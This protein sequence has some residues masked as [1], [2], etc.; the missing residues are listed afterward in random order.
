[1]NYEIIKIR[2][3]DEVYIKVECERS[4]AAELSEYFTFY[5][6]GY[7]F[8]PAFR[9]KLWDGKIRLFNTQNHTLYGGLID[10]VKKFAV[11]R[12]YEYEIADNL[13]L[14]TEFSVKEASD[15][16]ATLNIPF[17]V[18]DYQLNSFIR[19]V[20]K[21]R[22]LL[23]SP[24]ASGKS[25]IIYLL[26]RYYNA[27]TL[28][29]V[30]TIS[31]VAQ[32]SKDMQDYGY[33]SDKYIYQIM[34]GVDKSPNKQIVIST[35]QSIYKLDA[36]WFDQFDVVI[37]DEAHQFKAKSLTTL[38]SKMTRCKYR[39]GLT[40]TLDGTQT[41][42]LVL[43]GLFGKQ[44]SVTTTKELIDTGKLAAFKIK[45]LILK[46]TEQN[47]KN[48]KNYKYQDEIDYLVTNYE[49][50]R[51]IRNLAT[52]LKGNTLVLFQLVEKHGKVLYD[53]FNSTIKDKHVSFVHGGVDVDEREYIRQLTENQNNAI[54]VA[55]YGTFSTGINIR[56]LHNIIF[57]SPSKS[58]IRTL[59]SI[60]RG[61]RLGENKET[62]TLYDIADDMSYKAKK[63]F[64]LMHFSERMRI[65]G[66][67]KFEYKIYTI[68]LKG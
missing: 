60:G 21:N 2:Y 50:N 32:L 55:S 6:P 4:M 66:E 40:G 51:F 17:E 1:M 65:Y 34:A 61:L 18:R 25:L 31:L 52:S 36:K 15:F 24:T 38:L 42:K 29:I 28:I 56:N 9:N 10:Y 8:M 54:I 68:E 57:A 16:I 13:E 11:E 58:K 43:E 23:V 22:A 14:E 45:A 5:V 19:C 41:H 7:K 30:P 26:T 62:A 39:F 49:R 44:F 20:R 67:E 53:M 35:W 59:Q 12:E 27:K 64:T 63:N 47:S 33:D 46:H 37:G 48:A 3:Y